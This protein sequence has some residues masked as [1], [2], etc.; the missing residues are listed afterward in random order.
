MPLLEYHQSHIHYEFRSHPKGSRGTLVLL[1]GFLEDSRMW[2]Q[3]T[4]YFEHVGSILMI[5]LPGHGKTSSFGYEHTMDF[6]AG[7]VR[8]V[9]DELD[10]TDCVLLGHSMGGYAALAFTDLYPNYLTGLGLFFSTPEA[11]S[12][13]RLEMRLR[14]A[15]LVKKNKNAFIRAAIPQLFDVDVRNA[16]KDEISSQIQESLTL[17]TQGI[18][19]SIMGMSA[20]PNRTGILHRPPSP[21]M[22]DR[23]AVFAGKKDTV[24]PFHG[25]QDWWN[26]ESVGFRHLSDHG[27]MG[28]ISDSKGCGMAIAAWWEKLLT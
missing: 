28:H 12:P 9:L 11:D 13:E 26:T 3:L 27:H 1:H 8:A 7:C 22:P 21:L 16:F 15:E 23:I 10:L 17:D 20:R 19:A 4:P 2:K 6:M 24:I 25:V 5:D 14:A 18:L